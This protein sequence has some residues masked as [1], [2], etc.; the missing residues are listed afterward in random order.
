MNIDKRQQVEKIFEKEN[1]AAVERTGEFP[2]FKS[3]KD[4]KHRRKKTEREQIKLCKIKNKIEITKAGSQ[5]DEEIIGSCFIAPEFQLRYQ[6]PSPFRD[7][8]GKFQLIRKI[9]PNNRGG[10]K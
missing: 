1:Y 5:I 9:E 6:F 3:G 8:A 2:K 4:K 7:L 10:T